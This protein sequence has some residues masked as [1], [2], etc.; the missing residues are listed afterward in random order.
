MKIE[1]RVYVQVF[2][3]NNPMNTAIARTTGA[4]ALTPRVTPK[5]ESFFLSLETRR[6]FCGQ[7]WGKL[8]MPCG[9]IEKVERMTQDVHQPMLGKGA[10]I[11]EWSSR[12]KIEHNEDALAIQE[13]EEHF[14][15]IKGGNKGATEHIEE[16]ANIK[17]GQ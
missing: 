3:E 11:I 9:V 2:E 15:F 8:Q 6:K 1:A 17:I 10:P 13:G 7:Q 5:V 14:K 12:V 16:D 4:I